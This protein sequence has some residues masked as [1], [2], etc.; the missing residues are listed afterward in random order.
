MEILSV[1]DSAEKINI[2]ETLPGNSDKLP[3]IMR[4]LELLRNRMSDLVADRKTQI[5]QLDP[6][7]QGSC[8]N[9]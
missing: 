3:E 2:T 5:L 1:P 7:Q 9:R 4:K 6:A 8:E